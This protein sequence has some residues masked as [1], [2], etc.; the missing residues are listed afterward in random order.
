MLHIKVYLTLHGEDGE[1][2]EVQLEPP[3]EGATVLQPSATDIFHI[4]ALDVGRLKEVSVRV[5]SNKPAGWSPSA[6]E[7]TNNNS[8]AK[9]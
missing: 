6:I 3:Y 5:D 1:S 7:V 9:V 4:S 8:G 2:K